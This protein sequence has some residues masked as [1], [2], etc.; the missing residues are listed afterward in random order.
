MEEMDLRCPT[1]GGRALT[2]NP[3][4]S[5]TC[6]RCGSVC[7]PTGRVC[8]DCGTVNPLEAE[9]CTTCGR[10]LDL[11]G[12]IL[13]TRLAPPA[14]RQEWIQRQAETLKRELEAASQERLQRWWE[15]EMER[16][17]A[18]A[19]AQ[20]ERKRRERKLLLGAVLI[21]AAILAAVLV[22]VTVTAISSGT[23]TPTPVPW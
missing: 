1:C 11:V 9:R 4:G 22:Y 23:P 7:K 20:R 12:F 18:V 17:R 6:T 15:E 21:A 14:G 8:P 19:Q 10:L 16:R 13:E 2:P 3:D 5:L